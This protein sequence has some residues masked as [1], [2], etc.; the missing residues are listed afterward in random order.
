M[1]GGS[2]AATRVSVILAVY[3]GEATIDTTVA[4]ILGQTHRELELV[5]VDD[6][7]TD[8]TPQRLARWADLDDR[9]VLVGDGINR[10]RSAARNA[11]IDA[12]S[13]D[14]LATCD[15][16]DL[17]SPTRLEDLLGVA[18]SFPDAAIVSDDIMSFDIRDG[19][20]RLGHRFASRT[21]WRAGRVGPLDKASWALDKRYLTPLIRRSHLDASGATYPTGLSN[22][23]D[24]AFYCELLF[25]PADP[26]VIWYGFPRYYY[27]TGES[28]RPQ[29][30]MGNAV[31]AFQIAIEHTGSA[32]LADLLGAIVPGNSAL[33][34]RAQRLLQSDGRTEQAETDLRVYADPLAGL[35]R[36]AVSRLIRAASDRSDRPLRPR[37]R[38]E[39]ERLLSTAIPAPR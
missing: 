31:Q 6:G 9:V 37:A 10:G 21:T 35:R 2:A 1:T 26:L 36:L 4:S 27:R 16:D 7:S 32:E 33:A 11:A 24:M 19:S 5:V 15:A 38:E 12:A 14:W 39:I 20:V 23:E 13:G 25:D 17:Y 3:N 8:S 18:E 22:A 28:S 29:N 30:L 34:Q